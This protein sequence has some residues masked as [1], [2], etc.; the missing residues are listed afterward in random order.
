MSALLAVTTPTTSAATDFG[1]VGPVCL[2]WTVT[3]V[4]S[5]LLLNLEGSVDNSTWVVLAQATAVG[6]SA[7]GTK[8]GGVLADRRHVRYAR[9]NLVTFTAGPGSSPT[10]SADVRPFSSP[11]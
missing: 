2:A 8:L 4:V 9:A 5:G 10:L 11:Q 1:T 7:D 3:G 6:P